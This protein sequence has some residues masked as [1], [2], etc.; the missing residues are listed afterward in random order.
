[1]KIREHII[2]LFLEEINR[3]CADMCS[4]K[5]PSILRQT[6]KE[7]IVNL[8]LT[9]L[10][11]ELRERTPLLRSVV[12][13]AS[14][15]RSSSERSNLYWMPTVCMASFICLK[16]RSPHMTVVQ[17]LNTIFIQHS[18]LMVCCTLQ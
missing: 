7:D 14:I 18:G 4:K 17:L 12:M 9:K 13:A 11:D 6:N 8:S 1:M 3:E 2:L 15:R 10:E 16:N 5:N